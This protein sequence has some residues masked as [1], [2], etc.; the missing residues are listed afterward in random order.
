M[1]LDIYSST[2]KEFKDYI[3]D[4][5]FE[6]FI[7]FRNSVECYYTARDQD[8]NDYEHKNISNKLDILNDVWEERIIEDGKFMQ[9]MDLYNQSF[10]D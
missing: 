4:L 1:E 8:M 5:N 6:N 10:N 9:Q 2:E 3:Y 7:D